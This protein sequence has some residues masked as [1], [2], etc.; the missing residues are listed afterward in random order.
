MKNNPL[1]AV[2]VEQLR[3]L[4][5]AENQLVKALPKLAEASSSDELRDA[6]EQHLEQT[7]GHVERLETIFEQLGEKPTGE[8]CH[9]MEGL[10]KEG[11][12][13]ISNREFEGGQKD[14]ALIAAAQRVEHYEIAGYGTVHNFARLL[15]HEQALEL[16]EQTLGEEKEADQTLSGIAETVNLQAQ[17]GGAE[18]DAA[19]D[20]EGSPRKAKAKSA[21]RKR[22]AA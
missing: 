17:Q 10:V 15:D 5:S 13:I 19:E 11:K 12:E 3:D 18:A 8:V 16:L 4:Y 1:H 7:K 20:G 2:Y 9:G 14:A 22:S 6:F 21:T